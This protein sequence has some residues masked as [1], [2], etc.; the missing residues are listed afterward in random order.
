MISQACAGMNV[1]V[2][3]LMEVHAATGDS[4]TIE[5]QSGKSKLCKRF[6]SAIDLAIH[7]VIP[8]EITRDIVKLGTAV[9]IVDQRPEILMFGIRCIRA[10]KNDC[11]ER[12]NIAQVCRINRFWMCYH[13]Q[14]VIRLI[15]MAGIS[16]CV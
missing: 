13:Q 7:A 11:T 8:G 1:V 9:N 15:T 10:E 16:R 5:D 3:E 14:F 4:A 6:Q 2:A 12:L